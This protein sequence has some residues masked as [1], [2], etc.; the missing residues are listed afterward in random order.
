MEVSDGSELDH[1]AMFEPA[2][3][4][5]FQ[6]VGAGA[7]AF[8]SSPTVVLAKELFRLSPSFLCVASTISTRSACVLSNCSRCSC[9]FASF[10]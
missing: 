10:W 7:G 8:I 9:N 2:Y 4:P 6:N 3:I 5:G 1:V